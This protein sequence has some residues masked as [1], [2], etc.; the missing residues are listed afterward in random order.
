VVTLSEARDKAEIDA[1]R[2]ALAQNRGS[3]SLASRQLGISRVTL[4]RFMEKHGLSRT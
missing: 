2:T 4:Y 3:V 1:I